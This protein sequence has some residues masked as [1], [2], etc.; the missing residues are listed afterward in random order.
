MTCTNSTWHYL[1]NAVFEFMRCDYS[2]RSTFVYIV[3]IGQFISSD[4]LSHAIVKQFVEA[5]GTQ[6]AVDSELGQG[7]T[8]RFTIPYKAGIEYDHYKAHI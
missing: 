6:V 8:V 1:S 7:S 2:P 4:Q 3:G 5:H